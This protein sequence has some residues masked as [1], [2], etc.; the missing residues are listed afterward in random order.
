[1]IDMNSKHD[2]M[3][4]NEMFYALICINNHIIIFIDSVQ[5]I[6]AL[7]MIVLPLFINFGNVNFLEKT[8]IFMSISLS[9]H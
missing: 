1:M 7:V 3:H 8:L 4:K 6:G 5:S 2:N 9:A